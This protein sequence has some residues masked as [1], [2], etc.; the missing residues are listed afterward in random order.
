MLLECRVSCNWFDF[1]LVRLIAI[2]LARQ[3]GKLKLQYR[4]MAQRC[5]D[6]MMSS[7]KRLACPHKQFTTQACAPPL[8]TRDFIYNSLYG[9]NGYFSN[10][11][12]DV[13][14]SAATTSQQF[15]NFPQLLGKSEYQHVLKKLYDASPHGWLTPAEVFAPWYSFAIGKYVLDKLSAIRAG[16]QGG[17]SNFRRTPLVVFEIGGGNGTNAKHLLDYV[18]QAAPQIHREMSYTILEIS[19]VLQSKQCEV[20]QEHA[21]VARSVC[22]DAMQVSE[23]A[24]GLADDRPCFVVGLEVLDNL[25]HDKVVAFETLESSAIA[26]GSSWCEVAPLA[27]D[28]AAS[29]TQ[30]RSS[31]SS[32]PNIVK[33]SHGNVLCETLVQHVSELSPGTNTKRDTGADTKLAY[34]EV[35]RPMQDPLILEADRLW[36]EAAAAAGMPESGDSYSSSLFGKLKHSISKFASFDS[37]IMPPQPSGFQYS[38]YVPT[39]SLKLLLS[40][41]KAFPRHHLILADFDKLP[42]PIVQRST[43]EADNTVLCYAPA[44]V[45]SNS[46]PIV[47][48]KDPNSREYE[49]VMVLIMT[50]VS[51]AR[52]IHSSRSSLM[53]ASSCCQGVIDA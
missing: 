12:Q 33:D 35:Y 38:R 37:G 52:E 45:G 7:P 27:I 31:A 50:A 24:A 9:T 14:G 17:G 22:V 39:G 25:P 26:N 2:L 6:A 51:G 46:S 19:P 1:E 8:L 43:V 40:L 5:R 4:A 21:K 47:A 15:I 32:P 18:K 44:A 16:E 13:I 36:R 11:S 34:R 53:M 10:A 41:H 23:A 48:S 3:L 28:I 20:L 29:S 49:G 42:A 30:P